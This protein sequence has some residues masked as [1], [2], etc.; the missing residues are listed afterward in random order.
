MEYM[1]LAWHNLVKDLGE[2]TLQL[3]KLENKLKNDADFK[4]NKVISEHFASSK[5]ILE[6][7]N[8]EEKL[9][10]MNNVD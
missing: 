10:G 6:L 9:Y 8:I 7:K 4:N 5:E 2:F 3:D 1:N